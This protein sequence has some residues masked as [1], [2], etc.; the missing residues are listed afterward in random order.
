MLPAAGLPALRHRLQPVQSPLRLLPFAAPGQRAWP[1]RLQ[2]PAQPALPAPLPSR[3][4]CR[5]L[6]SRRLRL[7]PSP[8]ASQRGGRLLRRPC[9]LG[10]ATHPPPSPTLQLPPPSLLPAPP[11]TSR[12]SA[13]AVRSR[14]PP[15]RQGA[16]AGCAPGLCSLQ[17]LS[18][19]HLPGR[20]RPCI[21]WLPSTPAAS[22]PRLVSLLASVPSYCIPHLCH[23]LITA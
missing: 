17:A 1:L 9:W 15:R 10:A 22:L 11:P 8:S 20:Q 18:F 14:Q 13:A 2:P 19:L 16:R 3:L 5:Q 21:S 6:L 7:Q 23:D 12:R 4:S